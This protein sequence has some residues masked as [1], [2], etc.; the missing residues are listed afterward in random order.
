VETFGT[1]VA[2][3]VGITSLIAVIGGAIV[4]VAWKLVAKPHLQLYVFNPIAEIRAAQAEIKKELHP[5][6]GSSLRDS[7][8][9]AVAG[10][11]SNG[12]LLAS[13]VLAAQ[14]DHVTLER[15]QR[16]LDAHIDLQASERESDRAQHAT[17]RADDAR[18][19]REQE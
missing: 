6:G 19:E 16:R 5:N 14:A 17:E 2:I 11:V 4:T 13:H 7:V 8:D 15:L 9:R 10:S 18:T 1:A 12:E 3:A